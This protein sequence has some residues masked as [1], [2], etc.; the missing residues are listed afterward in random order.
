LLTIHP[1]IK[2]VERQGEQEEERRETKE[3]GETKKRLV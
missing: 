2:R 1:L 3:K